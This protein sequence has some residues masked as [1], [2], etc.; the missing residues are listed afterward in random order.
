MA[1]KFYLSQIA[2]AELTPNS[3]IDAALDITTQRV[4][5]GAPSATSVTGP[6]S[7]V[8]ITNSGFI[9]WFISKQLNPVTVSGTITFNFWGLESSMSANAGFQC[10]IERRTSEGIFISTVVNSEFGTEL[11]TS[12]GVNNWTASPTSTTFALGDRLVVRVLF[13]DAGGTM[14]SGFT[15]TLRAGGSVANTSDSWVQ[16]TETITTA[17][18]R[19]Y[20]SS[21]AVPPIS[22]GFDS[23][24]E[25]TSS[26][27]RR[28]MS[29]T[30][31]T[32]SMVDE[33]ATSA[34]LAEDELIIQLIGP[35]MKAQTINPLNLGF[36]CYARAARGTL[37]VTAVSRIVAKVISNDG[38]TVRGTCLSF[39]DKSTGTNWNTTDR[40]KA[41]VDGDD[42]TASV[43]ALLGDRLMIELGLNHTA[44]VDT[45]QINIGDN[46]GTD[47]AEDETTTTANN[48]WLEIAQNIFFEDYGGMSPT[49]VNQA[50]QRATS[51]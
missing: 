3:G 20:F 21:S 44:S 37:I 7:G 27:V 4:A 23:N 49:I 45:A 25:E 26:A 15:L 22:P 48:P 51:R 5:I 16:F 39:G 28:N 33:T 6:T 46:S 32:S 50:P 30:K 11:G 8:E 40:N 47:L 13:N 34:A 36:K 17:V 35:P 14:A 9:F 12:A 10:I 43:S 41:F 19:L 18:T 31:T 2:N 38:S 1:T 42:A 24:W 29:P